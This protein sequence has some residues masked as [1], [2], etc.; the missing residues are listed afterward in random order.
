MERKKYELG[1]KNRDKT[2]DNIYVRSYG[3]GSFW[4]SPYTRKD[5]T[6]VRRI[7][8]YLVASDGKKIWGTGKTQPAA[9]KKAK[10]KLAIY[11]SGIQRSP[12]GESF[13]GDTLLEFAKKLLASK[14]R[15][16]DMSIDKYRQYIRYLGDP[17]LGIQSPR[18]MTPI[19]N[20]P[21]GSVGTYEL[22][23]F[24]D[25]LSSR[26]APKTAREF[27]IWLITQFRK[28]VNYKVRPDNPARELDPIG[29]PEPE[30]VEIEPEVLQA[31]LDAAEGPRMRAALIL[32]M[33]GLRYAEVFGLTWDDIDGNVATVRR[34]LQPVRLQDGSKRELGLIRRKKA[35]SAYQARFDEE[36]MKTLID[37]VEMAR[38][39]EI[40]V[41]SH[42]GNRWVGSMQAGV[43]VVVPNANGLPWPE[44]SFRREFERLL[45]RVPAAKGITPHKFRAWMATTLLDHGVP[46]KHVQKSLGHS[47]SETTLHYQRSPEE[48]SKVAHDKIV[49]I[50]KLGA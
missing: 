47:R 17:T 44:T 46:L 10:S 5:G 28:A 43:R 19:G 8:G 22:E 50:R 49:Q 38:P 39:T 15:L 23:Q 6:P 20:Y 3:T 1:D 24:M 14:R 11:E 35:A 16:S 30:P 27:R 42:V 31:L 12:T 26:Y 18:G 36:E 33:H 13:E 25:N 40:Y 21:V 7:I 45:S 32:M 34:Q 4:E 29:V 48:W 41:E 9:E 2:N 37:S